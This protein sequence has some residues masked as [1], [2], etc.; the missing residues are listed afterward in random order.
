MFTVRHGPMTEDDRNMNEQL[1]LYNNPNA[2][3]TQTLIWEQGENNSHIYDIVVNDQTNQPI[4]LNGCSVALIFEMTPGQPIQIATSVSGYIATAKI[5]GEATQKPGKYAAWVQ[6]IDPAQSRDIRTNSLTIIVK[7]NP[8]DIPPDT[9]EPYFGELAKLILEAKEAIN[10]LQ[11][12]LPVSIE[13]GGTGATVAAEARKNLSVPGI[14]VSIING[15]TGAQ[16]AIDARENL[17]AAEKEHTHSLDSESITG[18]LPVNKGGTG[19][20]DAENAVKNLGL[21]FGKGDTFNLGNYIAG[22]YITSGA[23]NFSCYILLPHTILPEVSKV[24][25]SGLVRIRQNGKYILGQD[26]NVNLS[27]LDTTYQI[28][29]GRYGI[30]VSIDSGLSNA[31]NNDSAAAFFGNLVVTFS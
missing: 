2:T 28:N 8:L 15:G 24:S 26:L 5:P 29:T 9:A 20:D 14:P 11:S 13:N 4:P 1:I 21:S 31:D 17:G 10:N 27:T 25:V 30:A 18:V 6:V 16:N 23:T 12:L 7:A 3:I 22:G 19:A